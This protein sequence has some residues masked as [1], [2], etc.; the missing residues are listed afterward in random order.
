[1]QEA[2]NKLLWRIF[3]GEAYVQ[4]WIYFGWDDNN[5]DEVIFIYWVFWYITN[6]IK[7]IFIAFLWYFNYYRS[8]FQIHP[9]VVI[10]HWLY[11]IHQLSI[12]VIIPHTLGCCLII[13]VRNTILL[14]ILIYFHFITILFK[15]KT[16]E[17]MDSSG[18]NIMKR[19]ILNFI[20][21]L[22]K[23]LSSSV[24]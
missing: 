23:E 2:L 19:I 1:M 22:T 10:S 9:R 21:Y 6:F 3:C 8:L 24:E 14:S 15:P 4:Q 17:W 13:I 16:Y 12:T 5:D 18:L 7:S 11:I 20:F